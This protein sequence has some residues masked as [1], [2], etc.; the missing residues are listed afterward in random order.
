M[1]CYPGRERLR[2]GKDLL[3]VAATSPTPSAASPTTTNASF[4]ARGRNAELLT[5]RAALASRVSRAPRSVALHK[6]EP[7]GEPTVVR[8]ALLDVAELAIARN[9][10]NQ[11]ACL[12]GPCHSAAPMMACTRVGP[13]CERLTATT[14]TRRMEAPSNIAITSSH[15]PVATNG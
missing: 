7:R 1:C 2:P 13:P 8:R 3:E 4:T 9:R 14:P 12:A 10:F 15:C 11:R 6:Q 5:A